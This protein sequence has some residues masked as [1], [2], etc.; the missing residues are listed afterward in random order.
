MAGE[1]V[2]INRAAVDDP[3]IVN[4]DPHGEGWLVKL[5]FSTDSDLKQLM[6]AEQY[7]VFVQSGEAE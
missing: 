7:E 4:E 2:E 1:V 3:A 6:S 5:R